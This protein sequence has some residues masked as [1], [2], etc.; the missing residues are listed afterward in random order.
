MFSAYKMV[1]RRNYEG[2][3]VIGWLLALV[4]LTL[5]WLST[6]MPTAPYQSMVAIAAVFLLINGV[7]AWRIWRAHF[8]LSGKGIS[9]VS[10]EAVIDRVNNKPGYLW[11]GRG[12][13]WTPAHSQRV[14][15]IKRID[16]ATLYPAP[17][18]M[19]L[20][21]QLSGE[22]VG[23][24]DPDHVGAPWI[25]GIEPDEK[26]IY[27]PFANFTGHV[28]ILGTNGSGKTRLLELLVE[29][30][31]ALGHAV[32]VIDP[33][34]DQPF[35]KSIIRACNATGRGR[36]FVRLHLAFPRSGIRIDPLQNYGNPAELASRI[37]ALLGGG[38]DNEP[39]RKFAWA[40][41][42]AIVLGMLACSEKPTLVRISSY[43][44]TGVA[45]LLL[46]AILRYYDANLPATWEGDVADYA[47]TIKTGKGKQ[48]DG[49]EGEVLVRQ[50][51]NLL[52][53]YYIAKLNP[54]GHCNEPIE[55]LGTIYAHD[56]A[57]YSKMIASLLPTLSTLTTGELASLLSPD[58]RDITDSRPMT[59]MAAIIR[60]ESV[61][62][63]GLDSL[64]N[65]EVSAAVGSLLLADMTSVAAAI[66]DH[67]PAR[68]DTK[69]IVVMVDESAEV[70]NDP[71]V[72]LINKG[73]GAGFVVISAAQT[74]SDYQVRL[75]S[76]E[77]VMQMMGNFNSLFALRLKDE[78]SQKYVAENFGETY[79]K[80][81]QVTHTTSSKTDT[82]VT[83]F[84]GSVQQKVGES[85]EALVPP[86]TF[87][88]LPNWQ[89][90]A[91]I[92]GG[93]IIKGRVPI[94]QEG[95]H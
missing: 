25:H 49:D 73:R 35:E 64:A 45:D 80:A 32:I 9:F 28:Q 63:V 82:N 36:D 10:D 50:S 37:A 5:L 34:G 3:A 60:S 44:A 47:R 13:D 55:K 27:L 54:R 22:T 2:R 38:A 16:P 31:I 41:I 40:V 53:G 12:F 43:A 19:R 58:P 76:L 62:Y 83:H 11:L 95:A 21:Q 85:L 15:E 17:W 33:K 1:W 70:V 91:S 86:E 79:I 39:F 46:R 30:A 68:G 20:A 52:Y 74:I 57:H 23:A 89:Y 88:K 87:S 6:G 29:E 69:K 66:Y 24:L 14:Y 18:A 56:A 92:S 84:S 71:F 78:A 48:R 51:L 94:I 72:Q 93:R 8:S 59:D 75:G 61:L 81:K 7:D 67:E 90:F 77:K 42:N 4:A 65:S 26:D